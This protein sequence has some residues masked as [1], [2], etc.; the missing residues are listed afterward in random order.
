MPSPP[1]PPASSKPDAAER[2]VRKRLADGTI[3]EYRYPRERPG[4]V[5]TAPWSSD[6]INA[7]LQGYVRSP[8]W[9]KLAPIT[10]KKTLH[11]LKPLWAI[12]HYKASDL[13]RR[14]V[15]EIRD[16]VARGSG[17]EASNSFINA[18]RSAYAWGIDR[19]WFE[20]SP[21][22]SIRKLEGGELPTWTEEQAEAALK[23]LPEHLRRVVVL[24]LYTSQ[25]RG[26]LIAMQ[27]TQ[28]AGGKLH[29]VQRKTGMEVI[30]PLHPDLAKELEVW[31][32]EATLR[33]GPNDA[34][35]LTSP[36][37]Y[38]W[39]G[40]ALSKAMRHNL[41]K[42]GMA[43]INVHGLRKL[44]A[45]RL[46]EAGCSTHE[47]AAI[48]GHKTLAQV[49]HYTDKADRTRMATAAVFKLKTVG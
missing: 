18:G 31:R 27:W 5:A 48:T 37:G 46:A 44:A 14:E 13:R 30:M 39:N 41:N 8:Q 35:V 28:I 49:Q 24:G 40:Q 34:F 36:R 15:L 6:S 22:T 33:Q 17:P 4:K 21:F 1:L 3:K 29:V 11:Y 7:L 19:E 32:A 2:V 20:H 16:A 47:I 43:E 9:E 25:R 45:K 10:R 26:D 12:G 42:L 38:P 23:G